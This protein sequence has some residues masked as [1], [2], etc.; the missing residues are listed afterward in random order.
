[1]D[2]GKTWI[3]PILTDLHRR[4]VTDILTTMDEQGDPLYTM[5]LLCWARKMSKTVLAALMWIW[6]VCCQPNEL[7]LLAGPTKDAV[8]G[9]AFK[10]VVNVFDRNK[11]LSDAAKVTHVKGTVTIKATRSEIRAVSSSFGGQA[12]ADWSVCHV[13]ELSYFVDP[14]MMEFYNIVTT[15][16]LSRISPLTCITSYAPIKG[17]S[18]ALEKLFAKAQNPNCPKRFYASIIQGEDQIIATTPWITKEKLAQ[19]KETVAPHIY[20]RLY[21]NK[22]TADVDEEDHY[23]FSRQQINDIID[24]GWSRQLSR[25]K[26]ATGIVI[27][28][29][30]FAHKHDA[31][32]VCAMSRMKDRTISLLD[33]EVK[34]GSKETPLPGQWVVDT[35]VAMANRFGRIKIMADPTGI[36][37]QIV[38]LRKRGFEVVEVNRK[39]VPIADFL[40]NAVSGRRIRIYKDA[41]TVETFDKRQYSLEDE[42]HN[43]LFDN[44]K[45]II[46]HI[47]EGIHPGRHYDDRITTIGLCLQAPEL[48]LVNTEAITNIQKFQEANAQLS[49]NQRPIRPGASFA[50]MLINPRASNFGFRSTRRR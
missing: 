25:P 44:D 18:L 34:H 38:D 49:G 14:K 16:S 20:R 43:I 32:S 41:G 39:S 10:T 30:D 3:R 26:D 33:M 8:E 15:P 50:P 4:V 22:P 13:D 7:V 11:G 48:Q 9:L 36:T 37:D 45:R 27:C 31:S 42:F 29:V 1:M 24:M 40:Y 35:V 17:R 46:K 47:G 23:F 28:G 6:R 5:A 12:G 21:L 2:G 19:A